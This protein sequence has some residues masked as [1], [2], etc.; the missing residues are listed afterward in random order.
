M[1][2]A[3]NATKCSI[4]TSSRTARRVTASA[5]TTLPSAA[6][7]AYNRALDTGQQVLLRVAARVLEHLDQQALQG[8]PHVRPGAHAG[9][10]QIVP[11][12]REVLKR[13]RVLRRP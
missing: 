13:Q 7:R 2:P 10:D 12:D 1:K 3:P 11:V 8:V 9:G 6:I 4:S 5:P